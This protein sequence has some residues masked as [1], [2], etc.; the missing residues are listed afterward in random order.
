[1]SWRELRTFVNHAPPE[2]AYARSRHGERVDWRIAEHILASIYNVLLQAN[3]N[4][5]VPDSN[6]IHPPGSS[7]ADQARAKAK[8]NGHTKTLGAAELD[9]LF[10]G[11]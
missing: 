6:L 8:A 10:T 11:R 3:S 4:K 2:S 5:R 1:M 7:A 9:A